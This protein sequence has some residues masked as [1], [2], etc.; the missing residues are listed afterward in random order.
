MPFE[1][2]GFLCQQAVE[3][4]MKA[5][6]VKRGSE[7]EKTHDLIYLLKKCSEHNP[8]FMDIFTIANNLNKYAVQ[9]RYPYPLLLDG[10]QGLKSLELAQ[11]G[12]QLLAQHI[13]TDPLES[14]SR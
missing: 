2:I 8:D 13:G 3:K 9:T 6:L 1:V 12:C 5:Y 11:E 14:T 10:E 7:P 4:Y